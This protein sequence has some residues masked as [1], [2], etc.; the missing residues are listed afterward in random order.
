MNYKNLIR[1][2]FGIFIVIFSVSNGY[3]DLPDPAQSTSLYITWEGAEPDKGASAWLIK[4]F[5]DKNAAFKLIS[6]GDVDK[7]GIPFDV[8]FSDFRRTHRFTTFDTI[9][10]KYNIK[11]E[12]VQKLSKIIFDLEINTW[13]QPIASETPYVK[14]AFNDLRDRFKPKLIPLNCQ[15]AFFDDIVK[16]IKRNGIQRISPP[17]ICVTLAESYK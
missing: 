12:S 15:I 16:L 3:C 5:V 14:Q 13:R 1:V 7:N 10:L 6:K 17:T 2:T 4:T 9:R 8:P 11:D